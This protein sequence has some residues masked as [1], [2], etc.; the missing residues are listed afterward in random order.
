MQE[1]DLPSALTD[2]EMLSASHESDAEV[3]V[4]RV[5]S[6]RPRDVECPHC[7]KERRPNG[8]RVVRY[9]DAPFR[10]AP[11]FIDWKRQQFR[12]SG[13]GRTSAEQHPEFDER[14]YL[15][16]RFANWV[17]EKGAH[18]AFR[19]LAKEAGMNE[20][21]LREVFH[22]EARKLNF[23]LADTRVVAFHN[24]Q[25]AAR[26]R[27]AVIDVEKRTFLD[28]LSSSASL[29]DEFAIWKLS[30]RPVGPHVEFAVLDIAL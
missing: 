12:C 11:V 15:T 17:R 29:A 16:R 13:C 20:R 25:L 4:I 2:T 23:E 7:K 26:D 8:A 28:V 5:R 30:D 24:I 19:T 3:L 27:P 10:G 22:R 14:R 18:T 1:T 6:T 9:R 21:L